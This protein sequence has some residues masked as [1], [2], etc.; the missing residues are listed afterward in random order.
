MVSIWSIVGMFFSML[1]PLAVFIVI[2]VWFLRRYRTGMKPLLIGAGIF[3]VFALILESL[4][5]A[6][7]LRWNGTT[8]AFFRNTW[9]AAIYGALAAGIFEETGRLVA[10]KSFFNNK[11]E[12]KHGIAYGLG[13]G[14]LE[15]VVIGGL[16]TLTQVNNFLFSLMI[17]NGSFSAVQKTVAHV[18]AQA[19]ALEHAREQLIHLP[20]Y[21]FFL[22]GIE[23]VDALFIQLALSLL[24]LFAV[25]NRRYL[26]FALAVF[27]HFLVDFTGLFFRNLNLSP[28]ATEGVITLYAVAAVAFVIISRKKM[29]NSSASSINQI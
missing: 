14:G 11:T 22:G 24:V 8:A 21:M 16:L 29:V 4:L 25:A 12:W 20:S 1:V 26:F 5:N 23:R 10:F 6:F 28:L 15:V 19:A 17:N 9:L 7:L 2:L 13:H 27:L 18:P 3:L